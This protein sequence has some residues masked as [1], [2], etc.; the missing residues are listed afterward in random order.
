[1]DVLQTSSVLYTIKGK[2]VEPLK[3]ASILADTLSEFGFPIH[4]S[5]LRHALEAFS[6][7]FYNHNSGYDQ[8][9]ARMANHAPSTSGRYGRDQNSFVGIPAD[10]SESNFIACND[11]NTIILHSPSR[12]SKETES[13]VYKQLEELQLMNSQQAIEIRDKSQPPHGRKHLIANDSVGEKQVRSEMYFDESMKRKRISNENGSN[14]TQSQAMK[15]I[16]DP[17]TVLKMDPCDK[18]QSTKCTT[19]LHGDEDST[20]YET[21][22]QKTLI[23][24]G[25]RRPLHIQAT[26]LL[27]RMSD[28]AVMEFGDKS[29]SVSIR[30]KGQP[31]PS[32]QKKKEDDNK[33]RPMQAQ[34]LHCLQASTSS[35]IIVM[36][37][38]SGKTN[39]IWSYDQNEDKCAVIFTP[40]R[41]LFKQMQSILAQKGVT[42]VWPFHSFSGST[43]A[44]IATARFAVIP[45]EAATEVH[46]FLSA[47]NENRRLG[48]IWIDE[49]RTPNNDNNLRVTCTQVHVLGSKGR[50]R[51]AFDDFWN[52]GAN[53]SLKGINAKFIG[54]T[55][56]LRDEDV[57]DVMHRISLDNIVLFRKSCRLSNL[58]WEFKVSQSEI[59]AV[60]QATTLAAFS[61]DSGQ[62]VIVITT[63]ISLCEAVGSEVQKI[64]SG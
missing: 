13:Q 24:D 53:L 8:V 38:G 59:A 58:E 14:H 47:L 1:M 48:P 7:K 22:V 63:S 16:Q 28:D 41:V 61:A 27:Q 51:D 42:V 50:F 57:R 44:L 46:G 4:I 55:A 21:T 19:Q 20:L 6:H 56:T 25:G 26:H 54:L 11:W 17:S 39:L 45:Y 15:L 5:E 36:P 30:D 18:S 10:I 52:I 12:L 29:Q 3:M 34:A 49:V 23:S 32:F 64:F 40:Y 33:L 9:L 35:S 60:S 2:T 37:T 31:V 62:K 43:D